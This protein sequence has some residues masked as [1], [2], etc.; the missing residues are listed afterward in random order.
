MLFFFL[1]FRFPLLV[2]I[3][4]APFHLTLPVLRFSR[5]SSIPA[6]VKLLLYT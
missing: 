5:P 6:T 4:L 2:Y 1:L 3:S